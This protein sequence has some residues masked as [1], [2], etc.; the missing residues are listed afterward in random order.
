[1]ARSR[2]PRKTIWVLIGL[3]LVLALGWRHAALL[4]NPPAMLAWLQGLGPWTVPVFV[5]VHILSATL[6]VPASL[7]VLVGGVRFGLWWGSL[8]SLLGTTLGAV[9]AF[10]VA[11]YLL[12]DWFRRR[13][14]RHKILRQLDQLM[15]T[16]SM[17][18]VLAVRFAPLSPFNLVNFLFGLTSVPVTAYALGTVIGIAP[19]TVAYTWI[20]LAGAEAIAG[21][22]LWQ[23]TC[24][25]GFL[26]VLSLVPLYLQRR[27]PS[28]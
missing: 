4:F 24:A 17:N 26:A 18:C 23:L 2:I 25:L 21:R 3:G 13:F 20:G 14:H 16:H 19:G 1:M 22:G 12:Q 10:C 6:G 27:S 11:R 9:C 15:D 28:R 5:G 7:L 8:W